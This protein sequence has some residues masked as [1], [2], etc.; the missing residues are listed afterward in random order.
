METTKRAIDLKIGDTLV[1]DD[2]KVKVTETMDFGGEVVIFTDVGEAL[3]V[4]SD[5]LMRVKC[6][7]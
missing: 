5:Q 6:R 2:C 1:A 4:K 7:N 3:T